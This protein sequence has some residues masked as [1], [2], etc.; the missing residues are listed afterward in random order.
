M[1]L[2]N[3]EKKA[4]AAIMRK[5]GKRCLETMTKAQRTARARAAGLASAAARKRKDGAK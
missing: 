2:T 1:E 4:L 3:A 5:L